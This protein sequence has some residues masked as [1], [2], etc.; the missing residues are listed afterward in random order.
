MYADDGVLMARERIEFT[1]LDSIGKV[2]A[3]IAEEKSRMVYNGV[4]K[5]LGLEMFLG[6]GAIKYGKQVFR[7]TS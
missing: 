4:F 7:Y 1:Y 3:E 5:F 2:G 6:A